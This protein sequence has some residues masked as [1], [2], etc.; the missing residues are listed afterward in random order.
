MY[1]MRAALIAVALMTGCTLY[2]GNDAEPGPDAGAAPL[3]CEAPPP[4]DASWDQPCPADFCT[5]T[6]TDRLGRAA[7]C[8]VPRGAESCR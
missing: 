8:A 6:V 3:A 5:F 1:G 4:C 7:V 2:A